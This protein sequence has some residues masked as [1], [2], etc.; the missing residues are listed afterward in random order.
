MKDF[1]FTTEREQA[2]IEK[3]LQQRKK[4]QS[5]QQALFMSIFVFIIVI[6]ALYC[7]RKVMYAEFNG[8]VVVHNVRFR[9]SE[10]IFVHDIYKHNGD[11]V[12]PGDTIY[13]YV[14]LDWFHEIGNINTESE[15]IVK[16]RDLKVQYGL[17]YQ[18]LEVLRERRLA[19][20]K[21][22]TEDPT[23]VVRVTGSRLLS[24]IFGDLAQLSIKAVTL[25]ELSKVSPTTITL[26]S[27][28]ESTSSELIRS[29]SLL[30]QA[31]EDSIIILMRRPRS[32]T[33][34]FRS[35]II[36]SIA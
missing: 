31:A 10:D 25:S 1:H 17:A 24:Y 27:F 5:K 20:E 36:R 4:T 16:S 22:E 21:M 6:I 23:E 15:I 19:E 26:S 34:L 3:I 7:V 8:Y 12:R 13:S 18:N 32:S 2:E 28:C 14:S 33:I 9:A 35:F 30:S 29:I 11:L